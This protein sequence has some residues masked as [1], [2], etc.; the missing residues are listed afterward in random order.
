MTYVSPP[1]VRNGDDPPTPTDA[2][3]QES[4]HTQSPTQ[5]PTQFPTHVPGSVSDRL[6]ALAP[7]TPQGWVW[8]WDRRALL[9]LGA[10][11]A[12][13][14]S[15]IGWWALSGPT[16]M[17][18]SDDPQLT[19]GVTWEETPPVTGDVVV[20]VA[21][22]VVNPG[23][24]TMPAGSRVHQA[25]EQAGGATK[26]KYLDGVNLARVLVDGEQIVVGDTDTSETGISLNSASEA[27][28]DSLT[29]IGPALAARIVEWRTANG[30][31]TSI[32]Q[33]EEVSGIGPSLVA[34][35][36]DQVRL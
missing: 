29:G 33:L 13:L 1:A 20:H 10:I 5:S 12:V 18:V 24:F 35:I 28:L 23:V 17:E 26:A 32:D 31:F 14:V 3:V 27:E 8:K 11:L 15:V 22:N 36:R 4:S 19:E 34:S 2:P 30:P 21:G 25:I 7:D 9:A 16:V 6:R